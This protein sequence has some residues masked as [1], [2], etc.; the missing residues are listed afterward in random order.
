MDEVIHSLTERHELLVLLVVSAFVFAVFRS[1]R[2]KGGIKEKRQHTARMLGLEFIDVAQKIKSQKKG[3]LWRLLIGVSSPWEMTGKINGIKVRIYPV[4]VGGSETSSWRTRFDALFDEPKHLGLNI[5]A[6][7]LLSK[8]G[9][10]SG[11]FSLD[12]PEFDKKVTVDTSSP[13]I[14]RSLLEEP[15]TQGAVL[16]L[17]ELGAWIHDE[18]V[19][20]HEAKDLTSEDRYREILEKLTRTAILFQRET[21]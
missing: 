7:D 5:R 14:V 21:I 8:V 10:T 4:S 15:E 1:L 3:I 17:T 13:D 12:N 19:S 16:E 20:V 18:G 11:N 2:S 6:G 9:M